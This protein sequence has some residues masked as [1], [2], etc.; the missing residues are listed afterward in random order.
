MRRRGGGEEVEVV[1]RR[2]GGSEDV[3]WWR[4]GGVVARK[5]MKKLIKSNTIGLVRNDDIYVH[6][7]LI[8]T[9]SRVGWNCRN[10]IKNVL[11]NLNKYWNIFSPP[12]PMDAGSRRVRVNL[13][14][15]SLSAG[16]VSHLFDT[17]C[18]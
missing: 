1:V 13:A 14:G 15:L 17:F 4:G 11:T 12:P 8:G 9:F 5:Q 6:A 10:R 3:G 18:G 7:I 2:R 16:I